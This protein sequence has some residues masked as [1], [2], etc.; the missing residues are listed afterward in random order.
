M[1]SESY[2]Y[3]CP[4]ISPHCNLSSGIKI[5]HRYDAI[6]PMTD[7]RINLQQYPPMHVHYDPVQ[8]QPHMSHNDER[9]HE[10]EPLD[11]VWQD[12]K[13]FNENVLF[14]LVLAAM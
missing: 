7:L 5:P 11:K 4:F 14:D 9:H 13:I 2:K 10:E 1:I 3:K 6:P 12:S 8:A